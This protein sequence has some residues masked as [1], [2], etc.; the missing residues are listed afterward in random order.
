MPNHTSKMIS[1]KL[2]NFLHRIDCK[3]TMVGLA[4]QHG[5]SLKR[6]RRS[7]N[8][9]L[10]GNQS[11]LVEI[12]EKIRMEKVLWIA[13]AIDKALP[14]PIYSLTLIME[15][16]PE[17]TVNQLMAETGCTLIEARCAIDAAEGFV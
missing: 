3:A 4:T 13:E 2:N 8:W 9:L 14:K 11:Q 1:I 6:I 5:C 15:S 7:K 17:I 10:M 12:S 16:T